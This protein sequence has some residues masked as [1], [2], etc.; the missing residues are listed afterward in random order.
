[1]NVKLP[2]STLPPA[3]NAG[4]LQSSPRSAQA[5][6]FRRDAAQSLRFDDDLFRAGRAEGRQ[7]HRAP[8][9]T[10]EAPHPKSVRTSKR[11]TEETPA[12]DQAF[13]PD[14]VEGAANLPADPSILS[15]GI[16]QNQANLED[17]P[18]ASD[19]VAL[20]PGDVAG[21]G[22][23]DTGGATEQGVTKA[24]SESEAQ[25]IASLA[26]ELEQ[27]VVTAAAEAEISPIRSTPDALGATLGPAT[28]E[29]ASEAAA[30][31]TS[32]FVPAAE[33]NA[34]QGRSALSLASTPP[35]IDIEGSNGGSTAADA[36]SAEPGVSASVSSAENSGK[37]A[38][39]SDGGVES[40]AEPVAGRAVSNSS[41][42][43]SPGAIPS[44]SAGDAAALAAGQA[45]GSSEGRAATPSFAQ[46]LPAPGTSLRDDEN[47]S[48]IARG[49]QSAVNQRGGAVTLRLNPPELGALRI[50]MVV[51]DGV[52]TARF[53]AEHESVRNLL[54]DQMSHL[55]QGLDRQGLAVDRLEVR[56]PDSGAAW[57]QQRGN[58]DGA[59]HEGRS[60]GHEDASQRQQTQ[61]SRRSRSQPTRT[62]ADVVSL[63]EQVRRG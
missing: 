47:V 33:Q 1:M 44:S 25:V 28:S 6:G 51:R 53:T 62:F 35:R 14:G 21:T 16:Q 30:T 48:R 42:A 57:M 10:V 32:Q 2:G 41:G 23:A 50:D 11:R 60:A 45:P 19:V 40:G 9:A 54:M 17:A 7:E 13:N 52:V 29:A 24:S 22:D 36:A 58:G 8:T 20:E 34:G 49:L 5:F 61:H 59:S 38:S 63:G 46:V 26:A 4:T 27:Q 18:A 37:S 55:R 39:R 43:L 15:P 3:A 12:S 56:A 31:T